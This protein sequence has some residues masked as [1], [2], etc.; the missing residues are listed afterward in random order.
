M[1]YRTYINDVQ[2]FGNN[3]Y[4][5]I[6]LD[7]IKSKGIEVNDDGC[8]EGELYDVMELFEV[9]DK[10]TKQLIEDRHQ[11]V[12]KNETYLG[13]PVKELTDLSQSLWLDSST[14]ILMFNKQVIQNAYCFIP[15]QAYLAL[16]DMI[17]NESKP[18]ESNG[19]LWLNCTYRLKNGCKIKVWA[20]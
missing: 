10:L 2:I 5:D 17:E 18:Y 7:Y 1:A 19:V 9:I 6:W 12:L 8:Y 11:Q 14:P 4:Y 15:Y 20:N 13:N 3:E 16:Q